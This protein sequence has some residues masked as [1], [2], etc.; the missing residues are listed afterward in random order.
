MKLEEKNNKEKEKNES[1]GLI[2]QTWDLYYESVIT[3]YKKI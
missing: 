2:H 3:K 1:T